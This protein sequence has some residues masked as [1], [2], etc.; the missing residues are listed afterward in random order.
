MLKSDNVA[1]SHR[2]LAR[3]TNTF[4]GRDNIV[5]TVELKTLNAVLVGP[6]GKICLLEK[7]IKSPYPMTNSP[8]KEDV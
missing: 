7:W 6:A 1:R 5:R 3:I 4:P 2:P 8:R